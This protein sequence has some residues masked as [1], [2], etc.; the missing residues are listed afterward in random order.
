MHQPLCFSSNPFTPIWSGVSS[1]TLLPSLICIKDGSGYRPATTTD[2][3][4]GGG[5]LVSGTVSISGIV[6]ISG[7]FGV[8]I[9]GTTTVKAALPFTS[10]TYA[11]NITGANIFSNYASQ[12]PNV[13]G[14]PLSLSIVPDSTNSDRVFIAYSGGATTGNAFELRGDKSVEVGSTTGI[15]FGQDTGT[16][17]VMILCQVY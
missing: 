6:P 3:A 8:A 17:R 1:T 14:N 7:A 15:F 10:F 5:G 16:N 13:N 4:G 9:T 2:F 12:I 11:I